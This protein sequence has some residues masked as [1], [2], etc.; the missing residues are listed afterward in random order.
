MPPKVAKRTQTN[1]QNY[2]VS[3]HSLIK[4][5]QFPYTETFLSILCL[6]NNCSVSSIYGEFWPQEVREYTGYYK[7]FLFM[8]LYIITIK[9]LV[10]TLYNSRA[11]AFL[12]F[13]QYMILEGIINCMY[14]IVLDNRINGVLSKNLTFNPH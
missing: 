3:R 9:W 5:I 10:V 1:T 14:I 13:P 6:I 2:V 11:L 8:C 4:C 7:S 12:T